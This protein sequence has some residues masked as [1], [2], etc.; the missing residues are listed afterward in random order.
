MTSPDTVVRPDGLPRAQRTWSALA[1]WLGI[2]V[3]VLDS[4]VANVALP[5]IARE[6][7]T[8]PATS[9]WVLNAYQIGML[10][11]LLPLASLGERIG[12]RPVY[13]AGLSVFT[14]GSLG[15]ALSDSMP[16]LIAWRLVQG[17]GAA[18]IS[19]VNGALVRFTYPQSMLGRGIGLNALVVAGAGALGPTIA[20][21]ILSVADWQWLFAVNLPINAVNLLLAYRALPRSERGATRLDWWSAALSAVSFSLFFVGVVTLRTHGGAGAVAI[22]AALLSGTVLIRRERTAAR[23]LIPIDLLRIPVFALSVTASVCAFGAYMLAFT[24]LPF[25]FEQTLGRS[26]VQTGLLITPWPAALAL[27]APLAGRLSD[28]MS[29][30]LLGGVGML[31]LA[32]G[33]LLMAAIGRHAGNADIV[34][35]MAL[36]G[37]GFGLFQSPNNRT[38][39]TTAPRARSGAAGGTLATARLVGLTMGTA[40]V[41]LIFGMVRTNAEAVELSVAAGL[42]VLAGVA[43]VARRTR[44]TAPAG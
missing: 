25:F 28:R 24:A 16:V 41:A 3:S 22:A 39:L 32:T 20:S 2:A 31:V 29:A 13:L 19:A 44:T 6:L 11:A 4:S 10:V 23:P 18:G 17:L 30:S 8:N 35:R 5:Q 7:H 12:Y 37:I 27:V 36:C 34:W 42:A 9:T 1:I 21:A 40:A 33:L 14:V 38:M 26:Q 15:C 43:S